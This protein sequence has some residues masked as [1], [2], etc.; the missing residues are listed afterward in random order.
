MQ[1]FLQE[2]D[3]EKIVI[4]FIVVISCRYF[5]KKMTVEYGL[6]MEEMTDDEARVPLY[7]GK[8]FAQ[9]QRCD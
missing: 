6:V 4:D 3:N 5:F 7:D 9:I 2:D 8:V 1:I